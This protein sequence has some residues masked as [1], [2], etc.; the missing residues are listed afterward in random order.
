[1]NPATGR[2]NGVSVHFWDFG[3]QEPMHAA[4]PY[5]FT[6]RTLYLVVATSRDV[7]VEERIAYW[8]RMVAAHGRGARALVAVNQVDQHPMDIK[9]RELCAEHHDTLAADPASA[10]YATSCKPGKMEGIE[11]LRAALKRELGAM[12][13]MWALVPPEWLA[14]KATL[15][16]QRKQGQDTLSLDEWVR[17]CDQN[18][19]PPEER[20]EAL[21]LLRDLGTVVSFPGDYHLGGLGVLN[22]SWVTQ[23]IYPLLTSHELAA[24]RGL[25]EPKDLGKLLNDPKR[26]PLH[27]HRWLIEL[28]KKFELLFENE[29]RLLLPA[30]LPKDAP[31]W[32]LDET[33][34]AKGTVQLE[35][36]FDVLPESVISKFITRWHEQALQPESWWRHGIAVKDVSGQC[37]ALLRAHVGDAGRI[38]ISVQGPGAA[39]RDFIAVLRDD[40]EQLTRKLQG[41]LWLWLEGIHAEKYDDLLLLVYEGGERVIKRIVSGRVKGFDLVEALDLVETGPQQK[42]SLVNLTYINGDAKGNAFGRESEV[43]NTS[44]FGGPSRERRD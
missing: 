43:I 18:K 41:E 20:D 39:R 26:Y 3:G 25:L 7:G 14:T 37:A 32:A 1:M 33:W 24:A 31:D 12:E 17:L 9:Q 34:K 35:L 11:E 28:M 13:Q 44:S 19:V 40:L 2:P 16:A 10:F 23:A 30:R 4:H 15:E 42:E 8:L 29:G 6:N 27:K 21:R 36:R 38:E 22:P 5:F